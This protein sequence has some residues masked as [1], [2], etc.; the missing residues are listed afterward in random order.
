MA[1][2]RW[3]LQV[4]LQPISLARCD[5]EMFAIVAGLDGDFDL[6]AESLLE[7]ARHA[8]G[9]RCGDIRSDDQPPSSPGLCPRLVS[10][11]PQRFLR[12]RNRSLD[13]AARAALLQRL[14]ERSIAARSHQLEM[15]EP[16]PAEDLWARRIG[17]ERLGKPGAHPLARCPAVETDK[18]DN[19]AAAEI[20]QSDLSGNRAGR[21]EIDGEPD[22]LGRPG[23]VRAGIDIDQRSSPRRLEVN[24]TAAGEREVRGE[25]LVEDCVAVD[26]PLC[27][28][29][30]PSCAIWK[31][32]A[33][34]REHGRLVDENMCRRGR[35]AQADATGATPVRVES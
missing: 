14:G 26:R 30:M 22:A 8:T 18:I 17:C 15:A 34:F 4:A 12:N 35:P 6:A 25:R 1:V 7:R 33:D 13:E 32:R 21:R 20:A 31:G 28:R 27:L 19:D 2:W 9:E 16:G 29:L 10:Q 23:F 24:G 11:R 5:F 3:T